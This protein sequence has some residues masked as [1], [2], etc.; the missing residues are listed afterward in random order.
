[1]LHK[2]VAEQGQKD[3]SRGSRKTLESAEGSITREGQ[4]SR[5]R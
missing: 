1:M 5:G 4:V 2:K 3:A